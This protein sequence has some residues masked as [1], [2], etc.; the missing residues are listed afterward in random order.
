[1]KRSGIVVAG[2]LG[3]VLVLIVAFV[4]FLAVTV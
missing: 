2:A 1:V 4:I 3:A